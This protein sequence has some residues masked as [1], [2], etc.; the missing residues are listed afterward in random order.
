MKAKGEKLGRR[1]PDELAE[2]EK[3]PRTGGAGSPLTEKGI[4]TGTAR[5]GVGACE[6]HMQIGK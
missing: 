6:Y 1:G 3:E 2:R 5:V 4:D